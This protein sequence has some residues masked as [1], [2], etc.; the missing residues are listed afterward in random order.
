MRPCEVE[1]CNQMGQRH[2]VVFRS[3][4]GLD[5][6]LNYKYLCPEHHNMGGNSPHKNRLVDLAYKREVQN[7]LFSI[8]GEE[9]HTIEQI[10][11]LIGYNKQRLEKR[12]KTVP[13]KAGKYETEDVV[14]KLMGGKL[15]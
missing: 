10:A 5:I 6:E 15:Y 4:G 1:G 14:R 12:F 3:Q 8:L 13:Q 9:E 11:N 2:H 7:T